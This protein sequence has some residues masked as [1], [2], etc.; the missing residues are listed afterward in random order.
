MSA[1][2]DLNKVCA[3]MPIDPVD[4]KKALANHKGDKAALMAKLNDFEEKSLNVCLKEIATNINA[5]D[6][7]KVQLAAKTLFESSGYISAQRI[8]Y[9]SWCISLAYSSNK[10]NRII[11]LYILLVEAVIEFKR[12]IWQYDNRAQLLTAM[13]TGKFNLFVAENSVLTDFK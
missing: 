12:F 5:S 2:N 11:E 9:I 6:W 8:Y 13:G 4:I 1:A 3:I 10:Y 7:F